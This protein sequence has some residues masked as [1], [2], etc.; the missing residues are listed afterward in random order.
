MPCFAAIFLLS[1]LSPLLFAAVSSAGEW[2]QFRGPNISGRPQTERP[3]PDK[4]GP[5]TSVLWKTPL[6][7]G[8]SSPAVHGDHIFLTAVRGDKLLTI[9]LDRRTGAIRWEAIAPHERFD[10][11]H[12]IG[13]YAQPS[14][15]TDGERVVS[16]FGAC[17]MFCYD[18]QGM[19]LWDIRM[20]PV[21]NEYGAG[22]SPIIVGD[23]VLFLKDDDSDSYLMAVDKRTGRVAWKTDRTEFPRNYCTPAIWEVAG[24]KQIV[25]AATLRVVG[26]D[27]DTG[28]ELWTVRGI[29]RI[30][31]MSPVVGD[32][33]NLYVA[34]WT[35]GGDDNDRIV[36][37]PFDELIAKGDAN[38]NGVLETNE[39]PDGPVKSRF[40]LIDRDKSGT[41]TRAEYESMHAIFTG[42]RNVVLA[43]KPG[44]AGDITDTH[45]LWRYT[46]H[47][48]YCPSPLYHQGRL[49]L[50]KEGGILTVLDAASGDVL[51]QG[52]I[53]A[54]GGYYSS[55][56]A[57]DGKLYLLSQRGEV[58]ILAAREG[59]PEISTADF[60]E[61]S[62]ATPA[63]VDGRI[64]LRTKGHLYC[65]G[66]P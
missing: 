27:F 59:F 55:P 13:S 63:I 56:V 52:R 12:N 24:R 65:L 62:F 50:I 51:K 14:P 45:V 9:G 22:S 4:I 57:G 42:A 39:I 16:H 58:T 43:V 11:I 33:G 66:L 8:H 48:P 44:G 53:Q 30:V 23:Y 40:L 6:P 46:K 10:V 25:V 54:T 7:P 19:P 28:K 35:P 1:A 64:Y 32:D 38:K 21:A 15:A 29:A 17:G 34:A 37:I 20:A 3:L 60:G 18:M 41:V 36:P 26:Y 61:D 2:S 5:D 31:I 47:I 49:Y